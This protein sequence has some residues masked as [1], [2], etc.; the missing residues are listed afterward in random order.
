M[1]KPWTPKVGDLVKVTTAY[2]WPAVRRGLP[3]CIRIGTVKEVT[4]AGYVWIGGERHKFQRSDIPEPRYHEH[5]LKG[6]LYELSTSFTPLEPGD[7]SI[8]TDKA[9]GR[10]Y[11]KPIYARKYAARKALL[12][13]PNKDEHARHSTSQ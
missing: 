10:A 13:Q 9:G 5:R 3:L 1:S 2:I 4:K 6:D 8:P 12:D 7:S 11:A